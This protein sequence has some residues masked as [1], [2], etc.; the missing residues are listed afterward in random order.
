MMIQN[1]VQEKLNINGSTS[2]KK[3]IHLKLIYSVLEK[4][5]FVEN[6]E[7]RHVSSILD[8][9][10]HSWLKFDEEVEQ[11]VTDESFLKEVT[12]KTD[13]RSDMFMK[14]HLLFLKKFL[15]SSKLRS[16]NL[17]TSNAMEL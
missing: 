7:D 3:L 6:S 4:I 2:S 5:N 11:V 8:N 17:N 9:V 12:D 14:E 1:T 16:T 13:K 10:K 15:E